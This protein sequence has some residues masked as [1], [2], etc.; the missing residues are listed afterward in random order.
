MADN[1]RKPAI[2][3]RPLSPFLQIYRWSPTMASSIT[4][5]VTGVAMAAGMVLIAWWLIATAGGPDSYA[6]FAAV[7]TSVIGQIVLFGFAWSLSFHLLNGVRH[8]CWDIGYGFDPKSANV[9][10]VTIYALSILIAVGVFVL[11]H[12]QQWGLAQ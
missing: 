5:R 7:A 6:P 11:A 4:H 9:V 10:S 3:A 2:H 1:P 12:V 8:L